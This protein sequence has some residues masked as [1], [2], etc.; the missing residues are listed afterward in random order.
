LKPKL[1]VIELWGMGD[2][3]IATPFLQAASERYEVTLLAKAYG[4]D[5]QPRFWPNVKVITFIA[6]WTA[7]EH[8]HNFFAYP[9]LQIIRLLK[10]LRAER[11]DY[12]VSARWLGSA[13]NAGDPR[14]HLLLLLARVKS[15][16]GFP[17]FGSQFF[18]SKP[19]KPSEPRAHRYE[20]WRVMGHAL[21]LD[22]PPREKLR[23][24]EIRCEGGIVVHTGAGQAV[25]VWP[26]ERYRILVNRLRSK[27]FRVQVACD[28]DQESW[29]RTA[30]ENDVTVPRGAA[31]IALLE[32]AGA[33]IGNDSGPGHL[34]AFCG[35]PTFT[36][37][38]P[39][40]PE[41]F[42]PLHPASEWLDGKACP[43]KPCSDYC[44]FPVPYCMVNSEQD[45]VSAR[46]EAFVT[47]TLAETV[48]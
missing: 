30:G 3:V 22:L 38:G 20:N 17:R 19:L 25:R 35:V 5:L 32:K 15:R 39:Q 28:P 37:F 4:Q 45:E 41:W 11:F 31:L 23:F 44:R 27:G 26:L 40:L 12:G 46:V 9:W 14:D 21:G 42:A 10:Q 29:W 16:L 36:I 24:P 34:A 33:F 2:L 7:F 43:Y 1:L 8:K 6:P 47:R 18:L 13:R 48:G